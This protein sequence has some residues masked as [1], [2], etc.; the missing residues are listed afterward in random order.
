MKKKIFKGISILC[1][2]A[3]VAAVVQAARIQYEYKQGEAEY[4]ELANLLV[5]PLERND[6]YI[7]TK[8]VEAE[9]EG[10][11]APVDV[12][13]DL[14]REMNVGVVGWLYSEGTPINYPVVQSSDNAYYLNHLYDDQTNSSGA[15]FMDALNSPNLT[16][17]N[18]VIYGHNMK[19]GSMFK[20][21]QYYDSLYYYNQHPVMY[22]FTPEHSYKIDVFAGYI[23]PSNSE[24]YT[25][26]FDS[27]ATYQ[28]YLDRIRINSDINTSD[29]VQVT[30]DDNIITLVTCSYSSSL[31]Y[32]VQGKVT[33]LS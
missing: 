26:C 8:H 33:K 28:G 30:T 29:R 11:R 31:R 22:Y 24:A 18:T 23:T 10:E 21:L 16:D 5:S 13:F 12:N 1:A 9:G 7:V 6:V 25:I 20:S 14:L 4:S 2:L 32:V 19:N 3:C 27:A 15:I 17:A